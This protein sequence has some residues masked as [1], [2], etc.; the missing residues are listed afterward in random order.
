MNSE[1]VIGKPT[2]S[3]DP[4]DVWV[5]NDRTENRFFQGDTFVGGS[6]IRCNE[7]PTLTRCG[8]AVTMIADQL[9]NPTRDASESPDSA[10]RDCGCVNSG[11]PHHKCVTE[12]RDESG[13]NG[14]CHDK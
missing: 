5:W 2:I 7:D 9:H 8:H 1:K 10:N 4:C 3:D 13:C 12:C 11:S 6:C 14:K